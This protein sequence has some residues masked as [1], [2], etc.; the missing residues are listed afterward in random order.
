M[1]A[2]VQQIPDIRKTCIK[3]IIFFVQKFIQATP[4]FIQAAP[5]IYTS[6]PWNLYRLC[7]NNHIICVL[8]Y[9]LYKKSDKITSKKSR[10]I[11]TG[12]VGPQRNKNKP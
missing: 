6:Y 4:K 8:Q 2:K 9:S 5:E 7:H 1:A 12:C 10:K 3:K 11:Y